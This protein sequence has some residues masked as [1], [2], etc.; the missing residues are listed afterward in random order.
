MNEKLLRLLQITVA[1]FPHKVLNYVYQEKNVWYACNRYIA[2]KI[3]DYTA[4]NVKTDTLDQIISI[5]KFYNF[6]LLSSVAIKTKQIEIAKIEVKNEEGDQENYPTDIFIPERTL[7]LQPY[8]G[9]EVSSRLDFALQYFLLNTG[10][11]DWGIDYLS[12]KDQFKLLNDYADW[13][14]KID[15]F[16]GLTKIQCEFEDDDM[17]LQVLMIPK[18]LVREILDTGSTNE[19]KSEKESDYDV[20]KSLFEDQEEKELEEVN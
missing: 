1:K 3:T 20:E 5:N 19:E 7:F 14:I 13:D 9:E 15:T 11:K 4:F 17:K 10:K 8:H 16:E 2:V 12:Y 18:K 6:S